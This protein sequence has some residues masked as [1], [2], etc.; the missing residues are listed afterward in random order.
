MKDLLKKKTFWASLS[1]IIGAI[2]AYATGAVDAST[3]LQT[4][5]GCLIAIFMRDAIRKAEK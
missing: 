3:A 4:G 5:L 1:G 2:G